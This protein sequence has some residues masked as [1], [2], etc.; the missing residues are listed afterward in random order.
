[1]TNYQDIEPDEYSYCKDLVVQLD[2]II[3][4]D[5]KKL[6]NTIVYLD[7]INSMFDYLLNSSTLKNRRLQVFNMLCMVIASASYVIGID[8]DLSDI[9]IKFFKFFELDMYIIHNKYKNAQGKVTEFKCSN[10]LISNMKSKLKKGEK[11]ICCFDS[12]RYQD[13]IIVELKEYCERFN[14]DCKKDFLIYSSKDGDDID[15]KNVSETWKDKYVFYTPKI[16]YGIDFVPEAPMDVYAFFKCTSVSPLAFSQMVA[17]CRKIKHLKYHMQE[18]NVSLIFSN[19]DEFKEN[20]DDVLKYLDDVIDTLDPVNKDMYRPKKTE[21]RYMEYDP[22]TGEVGISTAIFD[23]MYWQQQYYNAVMRSS[24][25]DHFKTIL[26]EKGYDIVIN[27]DEGNY[28]INSKKLQ[29]TVKENTKTTV[30]RV[31]SDKEESLTA[32]E[33]KVKKSMEKRAQILC[34]NI[35][36]EKYRDELSD[37]RKFGMHLNICTLLNTNHDE[38]FI[39]KTYKELKVQNAKSNVTKIKLIHEVESMMNIST[40]CIDDIKH[41]FQIPQDKQEIIQKVF[42][43][44]EVSL[45]SMYRNLIPGL[46]ESKQV[47]HNNERIRQ[48]E[49][50]KQLLKY[51]LDLLTLR[52]KKLNNIDQHTLNYFEYELKK[53]K[54][55][56]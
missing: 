3:H 24:M 10:K 19:P 44:K 7:E 36:N 12:L 28:K 39:D 38:H 23:D 37:D 45:I 43:L 25:N 56:V 30:E 1:M 2:S 18:R 55:I 33:K 34:V 31:V 53:D 40:L 41:D 42:R 54:R 20:Y 47:R 21:A 26:K 6:K 35:D 48:Y 49:I 32:S 17:R 9:V 11:F 29:E 46:I 16:V 50:D 15:L 27:D 51:H 4:L 13:E 8:A 52:N 5:P 14:L 22:R